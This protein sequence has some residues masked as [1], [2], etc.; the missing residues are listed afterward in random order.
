[1]A[2]TPTNF[3]GFSSNANLLLNP[4]KSDTGSLSI[5]TVSNFEVETSFKIF[6]LKSRPT[7]GQIFPRS[8]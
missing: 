7:S 5:D 2:R 3:I 8:K 4:I 1:M 6:D